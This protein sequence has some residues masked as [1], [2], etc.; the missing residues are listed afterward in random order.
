[1]SA[2]HHVEAFAQSKILAF[3]TAH[4]VGPQVLNEYVDLSSARSKCSFQRYAP[5]LNP[6][7]NVFRLPPSD[8]LSAKKA[9]GVRVLS[10]PAKFN[11]FAGTNFS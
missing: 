9:P 7:L 11:S 6:A 2:I 8:R 3:L 10:K 5:V 4:T 1:M